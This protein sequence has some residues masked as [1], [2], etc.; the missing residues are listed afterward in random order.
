MANLGEE[1]DLLSKIFDILKSERV[2][3]PKAG[4]LVFP[5]KHPQELKVRLIVILALACK[6]IF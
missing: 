6:L 5:F 1:Q 2:F 3:D 4:D